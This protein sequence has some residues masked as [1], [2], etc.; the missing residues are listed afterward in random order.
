MLLEKLETQAWVGQVDTIIEVITTGSSQSF[1][2]V[3]CSSGKE[4]HT[5]ANGS[6][7]SDNAHAGQMMLVNFE[8]TQISCVV[9]IPCGSHDEYV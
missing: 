4:L 3:W 6:M 1:I 9:C 5:R 7:W 8:S 2:R